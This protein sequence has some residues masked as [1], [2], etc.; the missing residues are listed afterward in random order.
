ML[1]VA[2]VDDHDDEDALFFAVLLEQHGVAR[3]MPSL[4]SAP[5][6][7]GQLVP[8][9]LVSFDA[10]AGGVSLSEQWIAVDDSC[11]HWRLVEQW[12]LTDEQW[13]WITD[14]LGKC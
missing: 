7:E 5:E 12:G 9:Y 4:Q 8:M 2:A 14:E 6:Y 10:L 11:G 3:L 13:P 1:L